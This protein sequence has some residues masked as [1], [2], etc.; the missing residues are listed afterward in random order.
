MANP[1]MLLTVDFIVRTVKINKGQAASE[2]KLFKITAYELR[3]CLLEW[4]YI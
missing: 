1:L 2:S 3:Q 4:H